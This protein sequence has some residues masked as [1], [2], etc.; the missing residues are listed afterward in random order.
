M[1]SNWCKKLKMVQQTKMSKEKQGK[2]LKHSTKTKRLEY[3]CY[4]RC[5]NREYK[6]WVLSM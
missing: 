5:R 2:E 3:Q 6:Q 1:S 4:P